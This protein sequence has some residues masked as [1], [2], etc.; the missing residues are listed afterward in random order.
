[1]LPW[2]WSQQHILFCHYLSSRYSSTECCKLAPERR[3]V[4][5]AGLCQY[6]S[7]RMVWTGECEWSDLRDKY[8]AE[9]CHID[10]GLVY[11]PWSSIRKWGT[12]LD[13]T[14]L[15]RQINAWQQ[16]GD[17][18]L[19][20]SAAA[21]ASCRF[22]HVWGLQTDFLQVCSSL[23]PPV[24]RAPFGSYQTGHSSSV[25]SAPLNFQKTRPI[26]ERPEE[27]FSPWKRNRNRHMNRE[28][29]L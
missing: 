13:P 8:T 20:V 10:D 24:C 25:L 11:Y 2:I 15:I 9:R 21:V 18:D 29:H 4:F 27:P 17:G 1:M 23:R 7:W 19:T 12:S 16:T 26:R 6:D 22:I 5:T 14:E 3:H 28:V